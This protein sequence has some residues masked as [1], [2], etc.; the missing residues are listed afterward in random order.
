MKKALFVLM[1]F[2]LTLQLSFAQRGRIVT[3]YLHNGSVIKGAISKLPNE[4]R[5]QIQTPNGS[6]ILFTSSA[7]RDILYED[8]T[9]PGANNQP[10]YQQGANRGNLPPN[11]SYPPNQ[12]T[13]PNQP[14]QR[15]YQP[16][17]RQVAEAQPQNNEVVRVEPEEELTEED[18]YDEEVYDE[19]IYDLNLDEKPANNRR[20]AAQTPAPVTPSFDFVPGYH[21]FIDFGYVIGLGDSLHAFNRMEFTIT[22]GYQFTPSL[23]VGLGVGA[24]LYSDSVRMGRI[25]N[26]KELT[27]TLSYAFPLFV[28]FRYN[29]M[30]GRIIPFADLK[31]GYSIG[32]L[33][34]ISL[35]QKA[36]GTGTINKTEYKAESLGFY[37]SPSVGVK[38]MIGRSLAINMGIGYSVQLYNENSYKRDENGVF[39]VPSVIVKQMNNMGGVSLKAGLEF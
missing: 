14:N 3:V 25:V 35:E 26:N 33:K 38:L 30:T 31:A 34:T 11:Q 20:T 6:V 18:V 32:V 19:E 21:G 24:H 10:Q 9:R 16:N 5:F 28:D 15:P 4:E 37:V 36:D 22:Q 7:V 29:F 17:Q 2:A 23:F 1:M 8:G 12:Q 13:Q 39:V 27:S